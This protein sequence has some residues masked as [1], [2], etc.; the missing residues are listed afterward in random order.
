MRSVTAPPRNGRVGTLRKSD[1][2]NPAFDELVGQILHKNG[3][4]R[5]HGQNHQKTT[6]E[7][8]RS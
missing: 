6:H 3:D 7:E 2:K 5:T 4:W 1:L 8:K